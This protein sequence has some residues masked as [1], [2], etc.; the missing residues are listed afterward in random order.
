MLTCLQQ[1]QQQKVRTFDHKNNI[2][3]LKNPYGTVMG[4][5]SNKL[6][7]KWIVTDHQNEFFRVSVDNWKLVLR[8]KVEC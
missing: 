3:I 4:K 7:H 6:R 2:K 5:I 1:K 8:Q